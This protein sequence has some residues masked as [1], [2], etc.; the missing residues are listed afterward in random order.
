MNL[1]LQRNEIGPEGAK[2]W[3]LVEDGVGR[4]GAAGFHRYDSDQ[5]MQPV[6][7]EASEMLKGSERN[8]EC[9]FVDQT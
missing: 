7:S 4:K 2:A 5:D 1:N 3:C 8:A 9:S 6:E